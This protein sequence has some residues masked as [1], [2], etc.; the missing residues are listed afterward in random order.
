ML[1]K[2]GAKQVENAD[3]ILDEFGF[4]DRPAQ[5][6]YTFEGMG[7]TFSELSKSEKRIYEILGDYPVH[8]D[9]VVRQGEMDVGEVS[10]ILM[11]LE[12]KG[13]ARQLMGKRFVR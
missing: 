7:D 11:G 10:G 8:I 2:Q 13:L 9:E 4:N 3:D 1:I 6:N 12:L 5:E